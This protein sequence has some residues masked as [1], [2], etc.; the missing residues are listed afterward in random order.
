MA[1]GRDIL[2]SS[3]QTQSNPRSIPPYN[4]FR[5]NPSPAAASTPSTAAAAVI[6]LS[7]GAAAAPSLRGRQPPL[8]SRLRPRGRACR[9]RAPGRIPPLQMPAGHVASERRVTSKTESCLLPPVSRRGDA[10]YFP[11]LGARATSRALW[12][13]RPAGLVRTSLECT[14]WRTRVWQAGIKTTTLWTRRLADVT[15]GVNA[16]I[17]SIQEC[18]RRSAAR[19]TSRSITPEPD[20]P[21]VK[22]GRRQDH[23]GGR[24][25]LVIT[26]LTEVKS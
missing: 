11:S 10:R 12:P 6:I 5:F 8:R 21:P 9:R 17:R 4:A 23:F 16:I 25:G 7:L 13:A 26:A 22:G 14:N 1:H 20:C 18:L 15:P 24:P 2:P 3:F 19:C